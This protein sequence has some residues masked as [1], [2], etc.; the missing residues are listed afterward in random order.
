MLKF[1]LSK[2]VWIRLMFREES[3]VATLAKSVP[4]RPQLG[5]SIPIMLYLH[6]SNGTSDISGV[7]V[8]YVCVLP[9]LLACKLLE[10]SICVWFICITSKWRVARWLINVSKIRNLCCVP[11]NQI[12]TS[13]NSKE[14]KSLTFSWTEFWFHVYQNVIVEHRALTA[15]D[16]HCC[17]HGEN[18]RVVAAFP[19]CY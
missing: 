18:C 17:T 19:E 8:I 10:N 16:R 4:S 14:K 3:E 2:A 15:G 5:Y 1:C 9:P 12:K 7:R 11:S 13:P 6:F